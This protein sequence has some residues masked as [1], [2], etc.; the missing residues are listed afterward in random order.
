MT[1]MDEVKNIWIQYVASQD[2]PLPEGAESVMRLPFGGFTWLLSEEW[3]FTGK[4]PNPGDRP[5]LY[6]TNYADGGDDMQSRLGDWVVEAVDLFISTKPTEY[7]AIAVCTCR[8]APVPQQEQVWREV[9]RAS[10]PVLELEPA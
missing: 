1:A 4:L 8:F 2:H 6:R 3:S 10:K 7:E 9:P 5:R